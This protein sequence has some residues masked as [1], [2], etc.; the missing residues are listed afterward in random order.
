MLTVL[1]LK[2]TGEVKKYIGEWN[3][4]PVH[5]SEW[6]YTG[7]IRLSEVKGYDLV[8][9]VDYGPGTSNRYVPEEITKAMKEATD[10]YYAE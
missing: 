5:V 3:G 7:R 8:N 6:A 2:Q 1:T 10:A 4:K 9:T